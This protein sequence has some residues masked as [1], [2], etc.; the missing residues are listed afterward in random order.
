MRQLARQTWFAGSLDDV[1]ILPSSRLIAGETERH[2]RQHQNHEERDDGEDERPS[3]LTVT[4]V[5]VPDAAT[6]YTTHVHVVPT[7]G[8]YHA[9]K[10]DQNACQ[11]HTYTH[12]HVCT[13]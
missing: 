9:A 11:P 3:H 12:T 10:E 5:V 13:P 8:E 4:H 2:D 6:A 1:A 7:G